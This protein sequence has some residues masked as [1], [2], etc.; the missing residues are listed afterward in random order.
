[1]NEERYVGAVTFKRPNDYSF[2]QDMSFMRGIPSAVRF[3]V[4]DLGTVWKLVAPGY[5]DLSGNNYGNG[6]LYVGKDWTQP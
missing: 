6:A 1:M 5:G 3:K 2:G 4:Y